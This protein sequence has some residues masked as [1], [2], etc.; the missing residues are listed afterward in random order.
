MPRSVNCDGHDHHLTAQTKRSSGS[1]R[2]GCDLEPLLERRIDL[3][4]RI[5]CERESQRIE[6]ASREMQQEAR[7][8]TDERNDVAKANAAH[9]SSLGFRV[10][11]RGGE[12][13]TGACWNV[14]DPTCEIVQLP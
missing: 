4:L 14:L 8:L 6:I 12:R 11:D 13:V 7:H 10:F 5:R 2:P 9:S 3:E 1:T